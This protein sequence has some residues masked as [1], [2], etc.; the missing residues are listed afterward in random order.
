MP[1]EAHS[2]APAIAGPAFLAD[3]IGTALFSLFGQRQQVSPPPPQMAR[4]RAGALPLACPNRDGLMAARRSA[5]FVRDGRH[6]S[7]RC[8]LAGAHS[9]E[10]NRPVPEVGGRCDRSRTWPRLRPGCSVAGALRT[11]HILECN[12]ELTVTNNGPRLRLRLCDNC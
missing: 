7:A 12:T 3:P 4:L 2:A 11:Q 6:P 9:A 10:R 1:R 8:L 5:T